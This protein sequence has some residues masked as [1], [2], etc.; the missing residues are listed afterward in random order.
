[1]IVLS[2][3]AA[4]WLI[5]RSELSSPTIYEVI[6]LFSRLKR[7]F[8][9]LT[10]RGCSCGMVPTTTAARFEHCLA[11]ILLNFAVRTATLA[12]CSA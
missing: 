12:C 6:A 11:R 5:A 8:L 7:C 9:A 2:L 3:V 4:A 1:M 10:L